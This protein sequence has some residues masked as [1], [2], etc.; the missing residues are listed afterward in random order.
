MANPKTTLKFRIMCYSFKDANFD[1]LQK[2]LE[3]P[4]L[5]YNEKEILKKL[6]FPV[7]AFFGKFTKKNEA[8][9]MI[10]Q[11][12]EIGFRCVVLAENERI[13]QTKIGACY[14][15]RTDG[16]NWKRIKLMFFNK[17]N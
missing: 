14:L 2:M 17:G 5:N 11:Y 4:L 15:E 7:G 1:T 8:K 10:P 16:K 6:E 12:D 13:H 3:N 9:K